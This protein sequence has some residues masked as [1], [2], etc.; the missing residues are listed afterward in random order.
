MSLSIAYT[1][2]YGAGNIHGALEVDMT[3]AMAY[4][5]A[6][7]EQSKERV[8]VTTLV[9]KAVALVRR[10]CWSCDL[11]VPRAALGA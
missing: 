11:S 2:S 8:T 6:A 10:V 5:A 7:R 9:V 1:H 4:I 3:N